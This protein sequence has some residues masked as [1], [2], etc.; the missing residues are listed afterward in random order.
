MNIELLDL[1]DFCRNHNKIICYGSASYGYTTKHFLELHGF[2]VAFFFVSGKVLNAKVEDIPVASIED[3]FDQG[4]NAGIILSLTTRNHADVK[5]KIRKY[6]G[7]E[8]DVYPI[9]E[10]LWEKM[11]EELVLRRRH[12]LL[13]KNVLVDVIIKKY[14]IRI[15]K[16]KKEYKRI[17]VSNIV[18]G[19]MGSIGEWVL[20]CYLHQKKQEDIF[21]LYYPYTAYENSLKPANAILVS[22]LQGAGMEILSKDNLDF[23]RYFINKDKELFDFQNELVFRRQFTE[24]ILAEISMEDSFFSFIRLEPAER[25]RGKAEY[26]QMGGGQDF[27]CL[28]GRDG[29]YVNHKYGTDKNFLID[30]YR[31][32][33]IE[34]RRVAVDYLQQQSIQVVRMGAGVQKEFSCANVID[35]ASKYHS[36]F[37]DIYLSANC[38]FFVSDL[39]GIQSLAALFFKPIVITNA[40]LL[41]TRYDYMPIFKQKTDIA[42]LKKFW[43]PKEKRYL[44]IR[45]MMKYEVE[46]S[47][48]KSIIAVFYLYKKQ[49]II[50]VENTPEE[51][52]D[53]IQEMN[54]RLDGTYSESEEDRI[55]QAKYR[56]IVD[57]YPKGDNVLSHW[58]LGADFLRN[59][60]W[61]LD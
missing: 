23:W 25:A 61:L 27:V 34:T 16:I 57:D 52:R 11:Y 21:R 32:S 56:K 18:M 20:H 37:M 54:E 4:K 1:M 29:F 41:T 30:E 49:G 8:V 43:N 28:S 39:N 14:D 2:K 7:S 33:D 55:L 35:Y 45:E 48:S 36:E 22:K 26:L 9:T 51:I 6:I 59:N 50:P 44:T 15:E 5:K 17:C 13:H 24:K 10:V 60:Q 42:I 47:F 38:K 3:A 53:V 58:R 46:S 40:G 31:N 12:V 19:N